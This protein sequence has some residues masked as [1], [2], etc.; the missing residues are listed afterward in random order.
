MNGY[1]PIARGMKE[2]LPSIDDFQTA[3]NLESL[4]ALENILNDV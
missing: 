3:H 2:A 4:L 1:E